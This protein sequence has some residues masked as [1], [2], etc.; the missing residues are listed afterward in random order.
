MAGGGGG[1]PATS[2]WAGE[3][4]E[5]V[6]VDLAQ[7]HLDVSRF[8]A[9]EAADSIAVKLVESSK[10]LIP[11]QG[12]SAALAEAA[13]QYARIGDP[14]LSMAV[15][16][17]GNAVRAVHAT[18]REAA[19]HATRQHQKMV[20]ALGSPSVSDARSALDKASKRFDKDKY[21][22]RGSLQLRG[23]SL[24]VHQRALQQ[25]TVEYTL[26]MQAAQT[27]REFEIPSL[28]IDMYDNLE[29]CM[30]QCASLM[31]DMRPDVDSARN[32]VA[33]GKQRFED[34]APALH[35]LQRDLKEKQQQKAQMQGEVEKE[36]KLLRKRGSV[37]HRSDISS[38]DVLMASAALTKRGTVSGAHGA[39]T[40]T[41]LSSNS[42]AFR[43][44]RG[45]RCE[46][47]RVHAEAALLLPSNRVC[48][49]CSAHLTTKYMLARSLGIVLCPE[50]AR[51]HIELAGTDGVFL[52][53]SHGASIID[54]EQC[55]GDTDLV[56]FGAIGNAAFNAQ[57]LFD[58]VLSDQS[59]SA[60]FGTTEDK[61]QHIVTKYALRPTHGGGN[62]LQAA[63]ENVSENSDTAVYPALKQLVCGARFDSLDGH[64]ALHLA[65][66]KSDVPV[67]DLLIR[68]GCPVDAI[69]QS[70]TALH[71]AARLNSVQCCQVLV[72]H[73]AS[74][75]PIGGDVQQ[76]ALQVATSTGSHECMRMLE[77]TSRTVR[78]LGTGATGAVSPTS[79][80][81]RP[82]DQT[83]PLPAPPSHY[84]T[85]ID[86]IVALPRDLH[87]VY[88][89]VDEA[90]IEYA[91]V[92]RGSGKPPSHSSGSSA[93]PAG[94]LSP[95]C[96]TSN[97]AGP[98]ILSTA[99]PSQL[100]SAHTSPSSRTNLPPPPPPPLAA[101]AASPPQLRTRTSI[102]SE[103][104]LRPAPSPPGPPT[105]VSPK[106]VP[107]KRP[108]LPTVR[109]RGALSQDSQT[110][111]VLTES[112]YVCPESIGHRAV[113]EDTPVEILPQPLAP[114]SADPPSF[115][116]R[117]PPAPPP[118]I[119][120][121]DQKLRRSSS[122][123]A[124]NQ[125]AMQSELEGAPDLPPPAEQVLAETISALPLPPPPPVTID[126][127][128]E[129]LGFDIE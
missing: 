77:A 79:T 78:G 12:P 50:C 108:P 70:E 23:L 5:L 129:I 14:A 112:L 18:Q 22:K 43:P 128:E 122:R 1:L 80:A 38:A 115:G 30:A 39:V 41:R 104:V 40:G 52:P 119:G 48:A 67:V 72:D 29:M 56:L 86:A 103:R 8:P 13:L 20:S 118:P 110:R 37:R 102:G 123:Q 33:A 73:G 100:Q 44:T 93:R 17:I 109:N 31:R 105:K 11:T 65:A 113:S 114:Q 127:D 45:W 6:M 81:L 85:P 84:D 27:A 98:A 47:V 111:I 60:A 61:R 97:L 59:R 69:C 54:I 32:A 126:F 95:P 24:E 87:H 34:Q 3:S 25:A 66:E 19:V 83:R 68:N 35:A 28:L 36:E 42:P 21:K 10:S 101:S 125:D 91:E 120:R 107:P 117:L 46:S 15:Q 16:G 75:L 90:L 106:Q 82:T 88:A 49:D 121:A 55:T 7:R 51:I 26:T 89:Q 2:E 116:S 9:I 53:S 124:S 99:S 4:V 58:G 71:A 57:V 76:T 62:R 92:R 64:Q 94:Q 63:V 74:L 96:S